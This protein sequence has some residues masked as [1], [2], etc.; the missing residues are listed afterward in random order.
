[1]AVFTLSNTLQE[2]D[3]EGLPPVTQ[4]IVRAAFSVAK[5]A[6]EGQSR[7]KADPSID[8]IAHPRMVY[9]LLR[10]MKVDNP[11]MLAAAM[12]HD[13][14]EDSPRYISNP[15]QLEGDLYKALEEA[16]VYDLENVRL[17]G[18][19]FD[20][21]VQMTNPKEYP[22]HK[23]AYQVERVRK[24]RTVDARIL[25]MADQMAS[26]IDHLT[27]PEGPD[28]GHDKV[29][30]FGDKAIVLIHAVLDSYQN[31]PLPR[32]IENERRLRPWRELMSR[33]EPQYRDLLIASTPQTGDAARE[34]QIRDDF[35]HDPL[36]GRVKIQ[37][38]PGHY[39]FTR[40]GESYEKDD[41]GVG[42]TRIEYGLDGKVLGFDC[43]VADGE[44]PKHPR[45]MVER[46]LCEG[47]QAD[48][49]DIEVH[50]RS[51]LRPVTLTS[52]EPNGKQ[53]VRM[54]AKHYRLSQPISKQR[55]LALAADAG[56]LDFCERVDSN[57]NDVQ[58]IKGG[59]G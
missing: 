28:F 53:C 41:D 1:M 7:G 6:H 56:A 26:M 3:L 40:Y 22:Q 13:V 31:D 49:R 17:S 58:A 16:G 55:F 36:D 42:V 15:P 27:M 50:L 21:C 51:G 4:R 23:L 5:N 39:R 45:N 33:I 57:L 32:R 59:R 29:K 48:R 46:A 12:L 9:K 8:Y 20:L 38:R 14:L 44:G 37:R 35:K 2:S 19:V 52:I 43:W 25:K 47:I 10:H 18:R 54:E 11:A 34:A 30:K 24:M